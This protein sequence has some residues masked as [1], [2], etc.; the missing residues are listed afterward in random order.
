MKLFSN[1]RYINLV[2]NTSVTL[3][4][5]IKGAEGCVS[6]WVSEWVCVSVWVCVCVCVCEGDIK[7]EWAKYFSQS[8]KY[9]QISLQRFISYN[10]AR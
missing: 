8:I 2:I 7:R 1:L 3:T 6:G 5:L 10:C 4:C 9:V